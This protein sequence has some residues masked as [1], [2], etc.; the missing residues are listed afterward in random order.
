MWVEA[1]GNV[2]CTTILGTIIEGALLASSVA[3]FE[4]GV[5]GLRPYDFPQTFRP[6]S[7]FS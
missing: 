6:A 1:L 7:I 5:A 4:W 2:G 3:P